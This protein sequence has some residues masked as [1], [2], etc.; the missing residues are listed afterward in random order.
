MQ[1]LAEDNAPILL[2]NPYSLH[3]IAYDYE[4]H[5]S[6]MELLGASLTLFARPEERVERVFVAAW[7]A[8]SPVRI[9]LDNRVLGAAIS[10]M[11]PPLAS[12]HAALLARGVDCPLL[13][14]RAP[15]GATGPLAGLAR[16][17]LGVYRLAESTDRTLEARHFFYLPANR[18]KAVLRIAFLTLSLGT[19]ALAALP[20]FAEL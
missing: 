11:L 8:H 15:A 9:G 13:Q 19:A 6:L 1:A 18:G 14:L 3:G 17:A 20:E 2:Y 16:A 4:Y 10:A 7:N 12:P 5:L